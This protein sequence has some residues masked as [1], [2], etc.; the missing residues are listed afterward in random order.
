M[1][2]TTKSLQSVDTYD[3]STMRTYRLNSNVENDHCVDVNID[4]EDVAYCQVEY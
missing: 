1:I 4:N 2:V 3:A